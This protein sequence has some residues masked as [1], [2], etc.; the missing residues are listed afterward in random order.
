MAPTSLNTGYYITEYLIQRLNT[1]SWRHIDQ[2]QKRGI[3]LTFL[4]NCLD[5]K[6]GIWRLSLN[7]WRTFESDK[8]AWIL[9]ITFERNFDICSSSH[10]VAKASALMAYDS[11]SLGEKFGV[12]KGRSASIFRVKQSIA[13]RSLE[14]WVNVTSDYG[15]TS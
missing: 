2:W 4:Y 15:V 3:V 8:I 5:W 1:V 14:K 6:R 9:R 10:G 12:S 11:L 7:Y 13:L